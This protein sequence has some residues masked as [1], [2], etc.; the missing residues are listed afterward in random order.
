MVLIPK[1][2]RKEEVDNPFRPKVGLSRT[3]TTCKISWGDYYVEYD[4][5][6]RRLRVDADHNDEFVAELEATIPKN[7]RYRC[8]DREIWLIH[9]QWKKF[10][11]GLA[12]KYFDEV[13][14]ELRQW[15]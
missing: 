5:I 9:K 11:V 13:T 8:H 12:K 4:E 14:I 3:H 1:Q 15:N 2:K 6:E 7:D 10:I